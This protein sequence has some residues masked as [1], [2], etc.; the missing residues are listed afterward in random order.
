MSKR[1]KSSSPAL[2]PEDTNM[3]QLKV[4]VTVQTGYQIG[5][6]MSISALHANK[7]PYSYGHWTILPIVN[8]PIGIPKKFKRISSKS[9]CI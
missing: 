9:T 6:A 5:K 2:T 3:A 8:R 4:T 7:S 1:K